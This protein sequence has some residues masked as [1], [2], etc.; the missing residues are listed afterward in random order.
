MMMMIGLMMKPNAVL[1]LGNSQQTAYNATLDP[2]KKHLINR[3]I[4]GGVKGRRSVREVFVTKH[5]I[6]TTAMLNSTRT[7]PMLPP[8]ICSRQPACCWRADSD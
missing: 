5:K 2:E 4:D 7:H 6:K 8:V 3:Q 1:L